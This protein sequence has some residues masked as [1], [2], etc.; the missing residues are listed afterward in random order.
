ME[1]NQTRKEFLSSGELESHH[2]E[3]D[4][5]S[6]SSIEYSE[7]MRYRDGKS[8]H[9]DTFFAKVHQYEEIGGTA[10]ALLKKNDNYDN[11]YYPT[12]NTLPELRLMEGDTVDVYGTLDGLH[13]YETVIDGAYT[14]PRIII[15]KILIKG[16]DY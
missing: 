9:K 4:Y 2:N 14:V 16:I 5:E 8:G 1:H 11:L 13:I 6:Y 10:F 12:F 3:I 15:D 7:I